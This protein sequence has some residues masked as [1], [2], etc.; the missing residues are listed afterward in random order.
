MGGHWVMGG[1]RSEKS[2]ASRALRD[3]YSYDIEVWVFR[4]QQMQLLL[5]ARTAAALVQHLAAAGGQ[6]FRSLAN[7]TA[8]Q[9]LLDAYI[10]RPLKTLCLP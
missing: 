8:S 2:W 9:L 5:P 3:I 10:S 4:S 1:M 6:L 7:V